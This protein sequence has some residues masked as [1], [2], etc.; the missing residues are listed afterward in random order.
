LGA[1][2][3][4]DILI[5]ACDYIEDNVE[6]ANAVRQATQGVNRW[7]MAWKTGQRTGSEQQAVIMLYCLRPDHN[8][9]NG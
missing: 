1:L 4:D 5:T 6:A 8:I 7:S 9:T 3:Y 2:R